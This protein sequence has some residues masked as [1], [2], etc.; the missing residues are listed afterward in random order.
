MKRVVHSDIVD[1][2]RSLGVRA[3]GILLVHSSLRS[4]GRMF[5]T[6]YP[7]DRAEIVI[8]SLLEALGPT[9][10]LLL[11]ALSYETVGPACPVF[12][13]HH[14]PSCVGALPEFFRTR[15][16]TLRS[17]HP[18]HS[19]CGVGAR[20]E[21]I[22][23]G[24][25]QDHTPCGPHS[26]FARLPQWGGQVLF[27]GCGLRP[28]TSM[29]AIEEQIEPPYLYGDPVTYRIIHADGSETQMHVRSHNFKGWSQ[30]YDRLEGLLAAGM[31]KGNVLQSDAVLLE[32]GEMWKTALEYYRKDPLF[33]VEP[34]PIIEA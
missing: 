28:N 32:A 31:Q 8:Q 10:T 17:I 16:G 6:V 9:G 25:E 27:L 22:L 23:S 21:E 7:E 12:D 33:F 34:N 2:L 20:A 5:H 13:V 26:P 15:P 29:H 4:L 3:G 19:V 1:S 24:H 18:T 11:P 30:R 14:T